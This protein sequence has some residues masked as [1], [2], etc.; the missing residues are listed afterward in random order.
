MGGIDADEA[1][2]GQAPATYAVRKCTPVSV[3]VAS[4]AIVAF[5]GS[6]VGV[7][8][9]ARIWALRSGT[10]ASRA[11]VIAACLSE[12]GLM[13]LGMPAAFAIR[14]TMRKASHRS[15]GLPET[16]RNTKGPVVRSPRQS[17]RTRRTGTKV[18]GQP[19]GAAPL[20]PSCQN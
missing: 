15:I 2:A 4:G 11:L 10:P 3:K 6:G 5:G 18:G 14:A 20:E 13:C 8:W 17:S 7:A 19:D 16:G 1:E 12:C 9:R